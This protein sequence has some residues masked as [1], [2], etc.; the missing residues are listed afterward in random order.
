MTDTN[1]FSGLV[2]ILENPRKK[3]FKKV[4]NVIVVRAQFPQI[5]DSDI[6]LN[7]VFWGNLGQDVEK[8]YKINDYII[9]EGYVSLRTNELTDCLI[10]TSQIMEIELTVLKIYPF[11]LSSKQSTT[12]V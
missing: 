4:D 8:Y 6:I 10:Q 5:R 12:K 7:L 2:K 3:K 1:Y 9:I 11:L